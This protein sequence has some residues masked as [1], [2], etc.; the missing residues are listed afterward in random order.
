MTR[1][2]TLMPVTSTSVPLSVFHLHALCL[3]KRPTLTCYNLHT[4]GLR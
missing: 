1:Q 3:K 4:I 2:P